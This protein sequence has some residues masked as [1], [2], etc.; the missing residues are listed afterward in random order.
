MVKCGE[1]LLEGEGH[2][3]TCETLYIWS[4]CMM[5][6]WRLLCLIHVGEH[7]VH[8]RLDYWIWSQNC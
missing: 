7:S 4:M 3:K 1:I 6:L 5:V 8:A 2:L